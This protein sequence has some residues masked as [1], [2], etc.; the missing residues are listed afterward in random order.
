[1]V[2]PS[3]DNVARRL[4]RTAGKAKRRVGDRLNLMPKPSEKQREEAFKD[5]RRQ[6]R[7]IHFYEVSRQISN[8]VPVVRDKNDKLRLPWIPNIKA[9]E[10]EVKMYGA[11]DAFFRAL[12]AGVSVDEAML[13]AVR[14][15]VAAGA[16]HRARSVAQSMLNQPELRDASDIALGI[17]AF[18]ERMIDLAWELFNRQELD[19]V[20]RSAADEYFRT[21]FRAD[22]DKAG[23]S[24][25]VLLAGDYDDFILPREWVRIAKWSFGGGHEDLSLQALN[26]ARASLADNPDPAVAAS[27]EWLDSWYGRS[28]RA[29][30]AVEVP[31]GE[32]PFAI[33]DYKQPDEFIASANLGDHIQTIASMGHL[34]RHTGIT[35]SGDPELVEVAHKLSG[36]VKPERKI[37]GDDATLWLTRFDR[38][39]SSYF[40]LP[41]GTWTIAFGWYMHS[42]FHMKF[43]IPLNERLR[44]IFLSFHLNKAELLTDDTIAYLKKYGPIGCRDWSSV[45][46]LQAAGVPAFFSGCLTTTI[47]TVFP[48]TDRS[49]AKGSLYVD[50]LQTGEGDTFTQVYDSVRRTSFADNVDDAL[51]LVES[52][53]SKY[54]NVYTSRLHS[55]LPGRSVGANMEF[56]PKNPS[57]PRFD[58]LAFI[59]DS[60]YDAIR[61]GILD[62]INIVV[63]A[64]AAG[65]SEDEVYAAWREA[66]AA[67]VEKALEVAR[68]FDEIPEPTFSVADACAAVWKKSVTIERTAPGPE[69]DEINVEFSLDGNLKHQLQVVLESVLTNT[70]RPVRAYVLCRDHDQSDFERVAA[71]FPTVSFV[72]L[73]TD[74]VDY[75]DVIGMIKHITIATMDRLLLPELLPDVSRIIHHDLDAVTLGDLAEL[76]ETD[77]E[78]HAI[79]ARTSPQPEFR[80]GFRTIIAAGERL[81]NAPDLAREL[82]KRTHARH[83]YDFDG[84]NAGVLVLDL[85]RMRK[86]QFC[87]Q[88]L[89][90]AERFGMHDQ[91]ILN[92][93]AGADRKPLDSSWNALPRVELLSEPKIV[94]WAGYQKPW[95]KEYLQGKNYWVE[96]ERKL[97]ER[98]S[99]LSAH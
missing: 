97:A 5:A 77:L 23:E 86:D 50:T 1:M 78:G 44:P 49:N 6:R 31:A 89:P 32:I 69:G 57:D 37:D 36:R 12:I 54:E 83:V 16:T 17:V 91:E 76:Y 65:K 95:D 11:E 51:E 27:V 92:V 24:L 74:D 66:C 85:E 84:F 30:A 67:E 88:F 72:W 71:L 82:I 20:F 46:L 55:Y 48:P 40:A 41:E 21:G 25:A 79:A 87:R 33:I 15:L 99:A 80:S 3:N 68:D 64:I 29:K 39:A 70:S 53:R 13:Q 93:Y 14:K 94:H 26:H 52:Y 47:D 62:K 38:D 98:Q 42:I 8:T 81:K 90:Y 63:T 45:F 7:L 96:A 73:P 28:E 19:R 10:A 56:R 75:G 59:S 2:Q 9:V 43:D 22:P 35:Y 61:N 58:G 4:R 18:Q 60:E 34:V